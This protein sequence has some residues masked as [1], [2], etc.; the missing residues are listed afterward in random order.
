MKKLFSLFLGYFLSVF[1]STGQ[2][3]EDF[4]LKFNEPGSDSW[5]SLPLG[6]GDIT[7]QVW[8]NKDGTIQCYLAT[9]DSRDG[10][11]NPIKV[12]KLTIR[13][14]PDI[15]TMGK[16]YKEELLLDEGIF[17]IKNSIADIRCRVDANHPVMLISGTSAVP[18]KIYVTN[19]I[20]RKETRNWNK[21]EYLAEY[22]DNEMPFKP[23]ME[24]D[25]TMRMED[26]IVWYHRNRNNVFWNEL[27]KA[28]DLL[29]DGITNPLINRT[30]GAMVAGVG[31]RPLNDTVLVSAK[32]QKHFEIKTTVL[33][34]QTATE[35]AYMNQL[36][37]LADKTNKV[38]ENIL[39]N[40]HR[41]WWSDF[42]NRSYV[43]F[44]AGDSKLN[45]TLQ[46][47]NRGYILQRYVNAIGGRGQL[48]VK[49]N[50]AS[51]VLDTYNQSIGR[52]SGKSADV[53]LWGGAYWWQNTR[54][55]Y[56]PM[57]AS[58]D[59][60]L[61]QPFIKF[62]LDLLPVMRKMTWK[63]Y[64]Q[65]GARFNETMHFW[66]AWR[67][68]DIG[69][70]RTNLQPGIST[71]PYIKDLII[72]GLEMGNYLLDFYAY[73]GDKMMLYEKTIPFI[74]EVLLYYQNHYYHDAS[75][76]L[77]ITPAQA[78]ETYI[79]GVNPAPDIAGLSVVIKRTLE[80]TKDTAV[81][82]LCNKMLPALPALPQTTKNEKRLLLPI[83]DYKS[84][85]NVEYPELY[86][87]FPFRMYGV[88]KED[89]EIAINTFKDK[90]RPY[91]GWQQTG[92]QAALLGLTDSASK[93]MKSNGLAYDKRFRFPGFWGPNYDY[94]PDQCHAGNYINTIQAMLLQTNADDVY[95]LPAW[96]KEWN[97]KFK[98]HIPGSKQI[99][100]EWKNGE[101][102]MVKRYPEPKSGEVIIGFK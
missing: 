84:I 59:F 34:R 78:C 50:G 49:F 61:I 4:N 43:F 2:S 63:F 46:I 96:P 38:K 14:E 40:N 71:N 73:T 65:E 83:Q 48:P 5:S 94:T 44:G 102:V 66:G 30:T 10:M 8:T 26:C 56:Y 7:A 33:V 81:L 98:L 23:F 82:N 52:V 57:L 60:D 1:H 15:I 80:L 39:L 77:L 22:G 58:G 62:Y 93:I 28:N 31:L 101:M 36:R 72:T 53:R 13:F 54:L 68:G 95:L 85:I 19:N 76:K 16:G 20:W 67:G 87:I 3:V 51:L 42:W 75:G 70:N 9:S 100:A 41:K 32:V 21:D 6:N 91:A 35:V 89:N 69:W 88:G 18:V 12:G 86:P 55:I 90:S 27:M 99:E 74:K 45:D 37:Q 97:V 92:I 25:Q 11:D 79:N 29:N 47:L 17:R 64:K 24:A